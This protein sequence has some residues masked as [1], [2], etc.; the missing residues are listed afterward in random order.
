[1]TSAPLSRY[2]DPLHVARHLWRHGDLI[3]QF[4]RRE[5]EGRYRG[6]FLG[7]LWSFVHPLV[8]LMTYTFVF[9]MVFRARWPQGERGNLAEFSLVLFCGLITY[10]LFSECVTRAPGLVVANPS[11]V[12]KVVFPLEI[13][14][15]TV[16]G[17]AVFHGL[18]SLSAL[19]LYQL[20]LTRHLQPTVL[21]LPAVVVPL[22][23]LSLGVS[24]FL[25]SLG[26]Y[27]RDVGYL[28]TLLLQVLLFAT[29]VFYPIDYIGPRLRVLLELNPLAFVVENVRRVVLWG[30]APDWAG[31]GLW[32]LVCAV[33]MVLGYAWFMK[34]KRGFADVL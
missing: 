30:R 34:T 5:V 25:S 29:P 21:L 17:S 18:V 4:T 27:V 13:L 8:L 33:V 22:V 3:T 28:V 15:V 1:L 6:S 7:V 2:L 16:V 32:S 19:L 23:L 12:R 10:N 26:V 31:L 14:P 9:G 20:V 24:W 11:Y